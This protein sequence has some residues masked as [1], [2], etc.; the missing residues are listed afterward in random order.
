MLNIPDYASSATVYLP[1]APVTKTGTIS[2]T[3]KVVTGTSTKFLSQ[4]EVGG[5]LYNATD[6]E[7]VEIVKIFSDTLMILKYIPLTDFSADNVDYL[8]PVRCANFNVSNTGGSSATIYFRNIS[9]V[10]DSSTYKAGLTRSFGIS[11]SEVRGITKVPQPMVVDGTGTTI[12][13]NVTY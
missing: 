13:T 6:F 12:S 4:C 10:W 9:G 5:F 1:E 2:S 11:P 3:G 8:R 7:F